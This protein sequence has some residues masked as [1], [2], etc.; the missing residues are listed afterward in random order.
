MQP[1]RFILQAFDPEYGHPAFETMFAVERLEDLRDVLGAAASGDPDLEKFY[2]LDPGDVEALN[3]RFDLAFDPGGREAALSKWVPAHE[4][5]Y[6]VHTGY[7]LVLMLDGRKQFAR[8]G[9]EFF[10]PYRYP[11]EEQFDRVV[12]EGLLHREEELERFDA[13]QTLS[14]GRVIEGLR[15]VYYTRRGEEWRIPA[16]KLIEKAAAKSGWND[17]FERLEGMLFGYDEWQ[18]DWWIDL[19]RKR[20]PA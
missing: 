3:Q 6:L 8:M 2:T 17:T 1:C 14:D 7:E 13:P 5:P 12:A 9:G 18:S 10:P 20:R 19:Y 16:W 11:D 15:T 4:L